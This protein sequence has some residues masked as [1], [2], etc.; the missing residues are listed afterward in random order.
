MS[1]KAKTMSVVLV[2]IA[3][4][5][6]ILV[7]FAVGRVGVAP[8]TI[9]QTITQP[10]TYT[11][12]YT[13]ERTVISTVMMSP[14]TTTSPVTSPTTSPSPTTTSP[15][16]Q[17]VWTLPN[18]N[19]IVAD[20]SKRITWSGEVTI[21]M[22]DGLGGG[23][24]WVMDHL[25]D[26]FNSLFAGKIKVVRVM[27]GA[28]SDVYSK[29]LAGYKAGVQ[30]DVFI[31]HPTEIPIF[32]YTVMQPV[33]NV[34]KNFGLSRDQYIEWYWDMLWWPDPKTG[35]KH[36][37]AL[38]LDIHPYAMYIN[39]DLAEKYG[40][41]IPKPG[42]IKTPDDLL[43]WL[44]LAK[45]K[46]QTEKTGIYPMGIE[47]GAGN[48]WFWWSLT[49]RDLV[50]GDGTVTNPKPA[51]NSTDGINTFKWFKTAADE[52]LIVV[53]PWNELIY[54]LAMNTTHPVLSWVHGPWA[55]ATFDL[56][57]GFRYA[58]V[59]LFGG[60]SPYKVWTSGHIIG[61]TYGNTPERQK[62]AEIFAVWLSK[63]GGPWGAYAG[64]IPAYKEGW[65]F[66]PYANNPHRMQFVEQAKLGAKFLTLHPAI[67]EI[68]DHINAHVLNVVNGQET[69]EE[70]SQK[71]EQETLEILAPYAGG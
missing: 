58:V 21:E 28:W 42:E 64:H 13:T 22:W 49:P 57:P 6:G 46:L 71:S 23:D 68:G 59:A 4:V 36:M 34:I 27:Q 61:L 11:I 52:G 48:F 50:V 56:I 60:D 63:H 44:R 51:I 37:M 66:P 67:W 19:E 62:A 40:I 7:G 8:T 35:E 3:L 65:K 15:V 18:E 12:T 20:L 10:V 30:P 38:P 2:V 41:S 43:N 53:H 45:Q 1:Q 17:Y 54:G 69:P 25:V 16:Q 24:G 70:A 47:T 14:A 31:V 29:L 55:Q 33:D 39:L 9:T 32:A 26:T 5:I